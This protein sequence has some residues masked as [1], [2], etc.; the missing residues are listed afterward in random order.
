MLSSH[1]TQPIQ[2]RSSSTNIRSSRNDLPTAFL[3]WPRIQLKTHIARNRANY[4]IGLRVRFYAF[5]L[6]LL[7]RFKLG[8]FPRTYDLFFKKRPSH[9]PSSIGRASN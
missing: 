8:A 6:T 3:N 1:I 9:S 5:P 4:R 7:S 2:V